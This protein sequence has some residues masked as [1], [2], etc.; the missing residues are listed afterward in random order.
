MCTNPGGTKALSAR[1]GVHSHVGVHLEHHVLILVEEQDAERGHLVRDAARLW[2]P[3]DHPHRP[4]DALDGGVVG[5][6]QGL[7]EEGGRRGLGYIIC[8]SASID[9]Y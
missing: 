4:H 9:F 6:L 1:A 5:G 2:D 8:L 7:E 3:R